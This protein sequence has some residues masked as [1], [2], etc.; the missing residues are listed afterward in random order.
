MN[1]GICPRVKDQITPTTRIVAPTRYPFYAQG[2]VRSRR[3]YPEYVPGRQ[4]HLSDFQGLVPDEL[5]DAGLDIAQLAQ[6][7][8]PGVTRLVTHPS[9]APIASRTASKRALGLRDRVQA[10]VLAYDTGLRR[11][12]DMTR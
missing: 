11:P 8:L 1:C 7:D 12:G 2:L 4:R 3:R 5:A 6:D 9:V 10:V